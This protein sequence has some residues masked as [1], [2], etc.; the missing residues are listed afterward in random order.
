MRTPATVT[1]Q[2]NGYVK[3]PQWILMMS[4]QYKYINPSQRQHA[5]GI[6]NLHLLSVVSC[7]GCICLY[8][9]YILRMGFTLIGAPLLE[10]SRQATIN[11]IK[12]VIVKKGLAQGGELLIERD[13]FKTGN[14]DTLM[15]IN[16][17]LIRVE[18]ALEAFLKRV[19]RQYLELNDNQPMTWTVKSLEGQQSLDKFIY[20]FKW[21]DSKFPRTMPLNKIVESVE[22]K[23]NHFENE[24]KNK[25]NSYN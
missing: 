2:P 4:T 22:G 11:S 14:L 8:Y 5:K 19:D 16:D 12:D 20:R 3:E 13:K 10:K 7:Y 15:Y 23:I 9:L 21:N 1:R 25:V 24:L 18:A 6:P 17:K